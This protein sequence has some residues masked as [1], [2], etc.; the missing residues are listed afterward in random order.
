MTQQTSETKM[1][2]S[3]SVENA[4]D[5]IGPYLDAALRELKE[6]LTG[7]LTSQLKSCVIEKPNNAE[8]TAA[9]LKVHVNTL[10]RWIRDREIPSR[11]VHRIGGAVFFFPS[12]LRDF[13]KSQ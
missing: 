4:K 8:E 7:E 11:L 13:V 12:E 9:Y 1:T 3:I 6:H 10:Y 2:F 5:L